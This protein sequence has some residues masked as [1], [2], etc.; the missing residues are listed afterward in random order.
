[1]RNSFALAVIDADD[2]FHASVAAAS[3][4]PQRPSRV[5]GRACAMRRKEGRRPVG[6]SAESRA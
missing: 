6:S 2:A 1:L 3:R 4:R 5:L